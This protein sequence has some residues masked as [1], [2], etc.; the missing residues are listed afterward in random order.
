[1]TT[2]TSKRTRVLVVDDSATVRLMLSR[3]LAA[4]PRLEVVGTVGSAEEALDQLE[5]LAPDVMTLDIELPGMSG[6]DLLQKIR[7]LRLVPTVIVSGHSKRGARLTFEALAAGAVDVVEKPTNGADVNAMLA[8]VRTKVV[9]AS[10]AR[11]GRFKQASSIAASSPFAGEPGVFAPK[12]GTAELLAIGA[13]TGGPTAVQSVLEAMPANSP[14]IV[15]AI[16]MPAGFTNS[17]A[18]RLNEL[19]RLSVSEARDGDELAPGSI[20]VAPGGLQT[21]VRKRGAGFYV[22]VT[23]DERVNG[24]A[25][26]VDVLF[27]SVAQSA[28]KRAAAAILTGM[29]AD[30][31]KGMLALRQTGART[32]A[33]DE[34]SCV[35]FGMPKAAWDLGAA[36][37]LVPLD[38]LALKLIR[39]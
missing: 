26:S 35:V 25:P 15:V 20:L 12:R 29:G 2:A 5:R 11:L 13:S 16:H 30:G 17:Y 21:R 8:E 23:G 7:P 34:A 14:P 39:C 22:S 33:Q 37:S 32:F 27:D 3:A 38:E 18:Q 19:C 9:I 4:D 1:M 36:E 6:I 24:H 10:T 31:A 28:G